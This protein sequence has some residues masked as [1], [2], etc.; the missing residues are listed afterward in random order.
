MDKLIF[1][2]KV[3]S[4]QPRI[5]LTRSFDEA[6]HTYL[7]YAIKLTGTIDD[8]EKDFSIGIGKA[9]QA[10][11]N[12]KVNDVIS[13]ACLPVPDPDMEPVEYYKV[14][15]LKL[16]NRST[17]IGSSSAPWELVPPELE[18]Y[19]ERG[20]RRLATRTYDTKCS[21]CLW[22]ARMPVEIIVDNWNPRGR[23]KY[24]FETFC[25]GPLSCKLYK[26]GPNRKVE[27][28]N[29]MVY[30]EEDWVDEEMTGHREM[31]E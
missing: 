30:V 23:R 29:G 11:F 2:G 9:A 4:I 7:G 25:Y 17:T 15:K 10:K 8:E 16:I 20:H 12:F 3:I 22:G 14:S 13:G 19:R 31:D 24:R 26:A 1:S 18:V 6:S 21:S 28:R 5:R 27:G